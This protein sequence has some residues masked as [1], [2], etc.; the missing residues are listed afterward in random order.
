LAFDR[1][2]TLKKAEKL[3][4]QGRLDLAIV[5]Y[6]RVVEDNPGDWSTANTLGELYAK[7]GQAAQAIEQYARIGRHFA[8]DGFYPKA[9]ALYKKILKLK[10]NDE[11]A[12]IE[13][14]D[15]S[16]KQGLLADAKSYLNTI[17]ARRKARGDSRGAAEMVVR[18]GAI[19][20]SDFEARLAAARML[21]QMGDDEQ[22]SRRFKELHDD[23]LEKGRTAEAVE[24]LKEFV[25]LNPLESGARATLA[26]TALASG[27]I[28]GAREFLDEHSAG[29][30]PSLLAALIEIELRTGE[31]EAARALCTRLLAVDAGRRP[32]LLDTAWAYVDASPETAFICVD[33]VVDS[34]VGAA[35]FEEAAGALQQFVTR[36]PGQIPALLK[37]V[38]VCVDGGLEAA[39]YDA[40]ERL[41][42]AYL[43][44]NQ[45]AEARVIAEDLVAREPWE[46]AHIDRFRR[47]LVML[48]VSDPDTLIAERL[49]GQA[50]FMAHDPFFDPPAPDAIP[51]LDEP[52]AAPAPAAGAQA[53]AAAGEAA[54]RDDESL[55]VPDDPDAMAEPEAPPAARHTAA[56]ASDEIDLT[57]A[58]GG[59]DQAAAA[60][61]KDLDQVFSE[62]RQE[63]AGDDQDFS[64][65][66]MTL[67]RTYLEIGML[68]EALASLQTAVRS[69]RH[70]FEAAAALGRLH[71]KR[72]E[73]EAAI[74]WLE[75]AAEAPAPSAG[76]GHA[77]LYD[78]GVL[79]DEAGET[80]RA[81]AV[82]LELQA[83][84]G[85]YRDVPSR[86]DRLARVQTGG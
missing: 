20:P 61:K 58:L 18:L 22:A 86:I 30:D 42:D 59:L 11:A 38:E 46:A 72:A 25:R 51:G 83:D 31:L 43:A 4:R 76:D 82:F 70:R 3:V 14:A 1:D 78:L 62:I 77:L 7:A 13:L 37:L 52:E 71:A 40:Q 41:T 75:R 5:E 56:P 19:D 16:A 48:R 26:K 79:L 24:M 6:V 63:A 50:P 84:A 53:E 34:A 33:A 60:P 23:L 66:H 73:P 21:E 36:A 27:D 35:A 47:A 57:G 49:S 80:S 8:E 69:P 85:D 32:A 68:D 17:A 15:I 9:A 44:S 81:L 39:M 67:A 55:E 28:A 64:A 12:Q 2:G 74:E 65:Q 54:A 10:P 45:A 29:D